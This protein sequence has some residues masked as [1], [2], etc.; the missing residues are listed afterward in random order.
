M[1]F[2]AIALLTA[3]VAP[4]AFAEET[5][6]VKQDFKDAGRA[7]KDGV[8]EG[9]DKTKDATLHG[10]GKALDETGD[11]LNKAGRAVDGAGKKVEDKVE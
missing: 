9:Y 2:A 7:V 10:V 3:L 6:S 11:G 1:R 4:A 8:E 5:P